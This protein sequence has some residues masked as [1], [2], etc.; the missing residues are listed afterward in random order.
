MEGLRRPMSRNARDGLCI[1]SK[2]RLTKRIIQAS[3]LNE[4]STIDYP[5]AL[6]TRRRIGLLMRN[7]FHGLINNYPVVLADLF[8]AMRLCN[9]QPKA[10]Y[11]YANIFF[12]WLQELLCILYYV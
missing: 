10:I 5:G 7:Q 1:L 4:H 3:P 6:Y 12:A 2:L 9:K 8:A 11:M